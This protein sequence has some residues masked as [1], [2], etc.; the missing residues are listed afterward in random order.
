[1]NDCGLL[2][3]GIIGTN[4]T[5]RELTGYR[6]PS[7]GDEGQV[8]DRCRCRVSSSTLLL[9]LDSIGG[10]QKGQSKFPTNILFPIP[11]FHS[12]MITRVRL[13]T[14]LVKGHMTIVQGS[15]KD[16]LNGRPGGVNPRCGGRIERWE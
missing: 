7:I 9:L 12:H 3:D 13:Q 14:Q 4:G 16:H 2:Q 8:I 1:M 6:G 15:I 5:K 10:F 11:S